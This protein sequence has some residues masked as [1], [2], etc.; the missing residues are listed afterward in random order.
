MIA[1]G[2]TVEMKGSGAKPYLLKNVD[3]K[4]YTCSCPA[5]RNQSGGV[6]RTCKHLR[7]QLGSAHEDA[8]VAGSAPSAAPPAA[9]PSAA[10][11][12]AVAR[13]AAAGRK[14]RPDEKAKLNGPPVL[15]AHPWD[16]DVDPT[17]WWISEKLDGVRAYWDGK[18]FISR[19]GN[20]YTAPG[21]FTAPLPDHPLDGELWMGRQMFQ[22]T[23]SIVKTLDSGERWRDVVYVVFDAPHL[24]D[25]FEER[26]R[27]VD[28][29][30]RNRS[31]PNLRAVTQSPCLGKAHLKQELARLVALGAEGLMIRKPGSLYE[32]GR[33]HTLL[34]V[35]PFQDAEAVVVGHTDGKG[36]HKGVLG[37]LVLRM[38]DGKEF[39]VGT[40]L[41][42]AERRSP[43]KVG[44]VVTYSFTELTDGGIPKC[45]AFVAVRDYE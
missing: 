32:A 34:K 7:A 41:T 28:A 36:R 29:F 35:K 4:V 31:G 39:S 19:Q 3:G 2:Q 27:Q 14:L 43:P 23:I 22:K 38:P 42:D 1:L 20:V 5:W 15:L 12:A 44:A 10:G 6:V 11:Q 25:P 9:P 37:A 8:R 45:A 13:A 17:G 33:S 40:G 18:Q 24:T 21:W 30:L 16:Q 26:M